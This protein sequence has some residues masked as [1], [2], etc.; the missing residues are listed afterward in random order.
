[1]PRIYPCVFKNDIKAY[2]DARPSRQCLR[3]INPR[4]PPAIKEEAEKLLN[5]GFIY[6]IPLTKCVSN[7][8]P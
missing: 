4:K 8:V 1:M 7:T 2:L 3:A 5:V 6:P